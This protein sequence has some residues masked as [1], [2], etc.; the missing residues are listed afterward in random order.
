MSKNPYQP[1]TPNGKVDHRQAAID[2]LVA[3]GE[4]RAR[5]EAMSDEELAAVPIELVERL[6]GKK[7]EDDDVD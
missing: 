6:T 7:I 4:D 2:N 5:L 3:L 1:V